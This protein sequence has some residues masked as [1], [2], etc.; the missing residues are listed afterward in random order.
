MWVKNLVQ[1]MAFK[2]TNSKESA[3]KENIYCLSSIQSCPTLCNPINRSTPGFTVHTN[4]RSLLI[5]EV[6]PSDHL[7]CC[8][9]L[10]LLLSNFP[11]IRVFSNESA[12]PI[13]WPMYWSFSFS[14]G[15]SNEYLGL[16][17]LRIGWFDLLAVQGTLKSSNTTIQNEEY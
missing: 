15:L 11:S 17:V 3:E 6:M 4:S 1:T 12:L 13:R 2:K 14:I 7:I 9:P 5:E 16:I 10:L 8:H